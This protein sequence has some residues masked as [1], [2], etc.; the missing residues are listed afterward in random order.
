MSDFKAKMHQIRFRLGLRPRPRWGNLQRSPGLPGCNKGGLLQREGKGGRGNGREGKGKGGEEGEGVKGNRGRVKRRRGRGE[1][2]NLA[3]ITVGRS[4]AIGGGCGKGRR[5]RERRGGLTP[6]FKY[7]P[8]SLQTILDRRVLFCNF[9]DI[10]VMFLSRDSLYQ[11]S[12]F[13]TKCAICSNDDDR[14]SAGGVA[15]FCKSIANQFQNRLPLW[16][17]SL[18]L[19]HAD[20]VLYFKTKMAGNKTMSG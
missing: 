2:G 14:G 16:T 9:T 19:E 12:Y 17:I 20:C 10:T 11:V 3:Y 18:A 8:R 7:L 1:G 5:G 6:T 13:A 4:A 15:F